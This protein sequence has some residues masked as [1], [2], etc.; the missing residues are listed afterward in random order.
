MT[1]SSHIEDNSDFDIIPS[2]YKVDSE[3]SKTLSRSGLFTPTAAPKR[4]KL[5]SN[6]VN[7]AE[8][9]AFENVHKASEPKTRYEAA[10][11]PTTPTHILELLARDTLSSIRQAAYYNPNITFGA[12]DHACR[13]ARDLTYEE[14]AHIWLH[15]HEDD[16]HMTEKVWTAAFSLNWQ[17][18]KAVM[19]VTTN[20][21]IIEKVSEKESD[22]RVLESILQNKHATVSAL[23]K[24]RKAL[25]KTPFKSQIAAKPVT[26][27][28]EKGVKGAIKWFLM[29]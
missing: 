2:Y 10:V 23:R 27:V 24:S 6:R 22:P 29:N 17:W 8:V 3:E 16:F 15:T 13:I 14:A 20:S 21:R 25:E 5:A 9:N 4:P 1:Y 12:L 11:S 18:R 7:H 28:T 26:P 19:T